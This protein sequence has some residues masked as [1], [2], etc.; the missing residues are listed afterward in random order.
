[1]ELNANKITAEIMPVNIATD[2]SVFP[3]H[4]PFFVESL[5]VEGFSGGTWQLLNPSVDY[6]MGPLYT[7]AAAATGK[8]I[9]SYFL[10]IK[11]VSQVRYNYHVLGQYED[12]KLLSEITA[13]GINRAKLIDWLKIKGSASTWG[14]LTRDPRLMGSSMLEILVEQMTAIKLALGN[15]YTYDMNYGPML[16]ELEAKVNAIPGLNDL[17]ERRDTPDASVVVTANNGREVYMLPSGKQSMAGVVSFVSTDKTD[18]E[19]AHVIIT[20]SNN[21]PKISVYGRTGSRVDPI[22]TYL[23]TPVTG[24]T[25]LTVTARYAGTINLK[26]FTQF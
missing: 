18:I 5:R 4:G 8:E 21:T 13:S 26:I 9:F 2:I 10:L 6:V 16:T 22:M 7:G 23:V 19:T 12:T 17:D 20:T 24:Q 14:T 1:M 11:N 25:R 15:P 3:K